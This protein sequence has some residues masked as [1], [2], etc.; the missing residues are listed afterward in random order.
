MVPSK[1]QCYKL[2]DKYN[3]SQKKR[4]H[5]NL[6][7]KVALFLGKKLKE[8]GIII[9]LDLLSAAAYLHDIDKNAP[10]RKG[11][12]HPES[13]VRILKEEKLKEVA[14]VVRRHSLH[15][16][17]DNKF[18]PQSWEQRLLYLA[19]K[20]VKQSVI[21]VNERFKLWRNEN[22]P[23]DVF[24]VLGATYPLVKHL[25]EQIFELAGTTLFDIKNSI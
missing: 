6:V 25:K 14:E 20:M 21:G 24:D 2:W 9:N 5:S 22:L 8:K 16:I 7:C 23:Q 19:D 3:L 15:C 13:A 4:I 1:K 11:E 18:A 17:L 10:K 12:K